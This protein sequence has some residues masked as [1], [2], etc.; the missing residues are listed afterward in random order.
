MGWNNV[1][2]STGYRGSAYASNPECRSKL[3]ASN[4]KSNLLVRQT[5]AFNAALPLSSIRNFG[6]YIRGGES[7]QYLDE[8]RRRGQ[9]NEVARSH[10]GAV[11]PPG[12]GLVGGQRG[13]QPP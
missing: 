13:G 4:C 5:D 12:R 11:G 7:R 8:L 1:P 9:R 10:A 6:G 2:G 3:G